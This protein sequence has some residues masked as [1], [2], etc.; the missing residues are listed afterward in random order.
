MV[1]SFGA[2]VFLN[3]LLE[4]LK[5][6]D[7]SNSSDGASAATKTLIMLAPLYNAQ[8]MDSDQSDRV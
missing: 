4:E 3:G 8:G 2:G 1:I 6:Q 5:K 7:S